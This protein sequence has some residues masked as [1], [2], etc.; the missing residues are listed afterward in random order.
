MST[1]HSLI[2]V[3]TFVDPKLILDKAEDFPSTAMLVE[4]LLPYYQLAQ[5]FTSG[6]TTPS[7]RIGSRQP[8]YN[9]LPESLENEVQQELRSLQHSAFVLEAAGDK[10]RAQEIR[11]VAKTLTSMVDTIK[12][13]ETTKSMIPIGR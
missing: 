3:E 7:Q 6:P 11:S 4:R 5:N 8:D 10:T 1:E 2:Q 13:I 9:A 12:K